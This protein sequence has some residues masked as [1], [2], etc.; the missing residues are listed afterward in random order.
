MKTASWTW[1]L[2]AGLA[3]ASSGAFAQQQQDPFPLPPKEWPKPVMDTEPFSLLLLDRLEYRLRAG[4]DAWAW[5]GE[6]WFGG[7]YNKFW[8]KSEGEA[9][10]RGRAE[11]ADIQALYARRIAPFWHLQAG[12]R[13]EA[14]PT[15]S[16]NQGVLAIEGLAPY[17]FNVQASAFIGR[18]SVSGRVEAT[19]DQL[20]TQRLILQPRLETNF[21]GSSDTAR[22]IGKGLTDVELGLRLRYEIKREFAPYVG[23]TWTRQLGDTADL[24]RQQGKDVTEKAI[25]VGIR[26]WY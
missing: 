7:D 16:R 21:A 3:C 9:E 13:Q 12:V 26:V 5:E 6:A 14:R 20:L 25:V 1:L 18:G 17:W 8:L 22:G 15:P 24:S 2:A 19:Y 11:S 10:I 23:V 4:K